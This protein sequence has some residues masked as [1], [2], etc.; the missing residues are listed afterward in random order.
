MSIGA[1]VRRRFRQLRAAAACAQTA[2]VKRVLK[3][4]T[5]AILG[6]MRLNFLSVSTRKFAQVT[7]K[8][9]KALVKKLG[10]LKS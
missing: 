2:W 10:L 1:S 8:R 5:R 6:L 3:L 4:Q 9:E 7:F